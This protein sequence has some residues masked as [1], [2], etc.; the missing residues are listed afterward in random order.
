[1]GLQAM[2]ILVFQHI[3]VEHPG[4]FRAMMAADGIAWDTVALDEGDAIPPLGGYAALLV[5]GGP[6]DVWEE[7]RHPWLA[8]EK[9][10]I[11]RWV[12]G[13][14]PFLGVCLGHQLLAAALGGR[15][16]LMPAP[17]VG[18]IDVALTDPAD[19]LFAGLASPLSC[20]QWHGAEVQVPPPGAVVTAGNDACRV[21]AMRV[22]TAAW[23]IQFHVEVTPQTVPEWSAIPAYAASLQRVLG[24]GGGARLEAA[25]A[26]RM[27]AFSAAAETVWAN[28]RHLL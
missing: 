16:G 5:M 13:G 19:A 7:D 12:E 23:G 18:I 17:E 10:A 1:M 25:T 6:M 26:A 21:Q 22:G 27:A 3:A 8:A 20:L 11:R 24:D 14:R 2:R 4:S 15:V 28:F 9:D